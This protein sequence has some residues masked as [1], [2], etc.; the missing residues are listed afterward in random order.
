MH[1]PSVRMS[2]MQP[3]RTGS[4]PVKSFTLRGCASL[5]CMLL[6]ILA[7]FQAAW[8]GPGHDHADEAPVASGDGPARAADGS[9]FLPKPSQRQL[10]IRTRIAEAGEAPRSMAL[11]GQ[12]VMDPS[13][14]GKVQAAMAGRIEAGPAGLPALGARVSA[15]QVLAHIRPVA[16]AIERANQAAADAELRSALEIARQRVVRLDQ[17]E[18]SVPQKD[19]DAARA[20]LRGLTE[21]SRAVAGSLAGREALVAPVSGVIAS[22]NAV[23]GQIV[24][25]REL[26]FEIIDPARLRV[27]ALAFDP[28]M[29]QAITGAAA[30][31]GG[32]KVDLKPLGAARSLRDGALPVQFAVLKAADA[33]LALGMPV[34][35][36]VA[37]RERVQGVVLPAAAVVRN[38]AN[39]DIV[40]VHEAAERFVP[41][42][43]RAQAV[44]GATVVITDGLKPG[45]RVVVQGAALV[46]QVR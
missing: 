40:W 33:P 10:M 21:R 22:A 19:I 9:V 24:D 7:P 23:V 5:A 35:V 15:G 45:Q 32:R 29:A 20:E 36:F 18:G 43:V 11:M 28:A 2:N 4:G 3:T 13:A 6:L 17:L 34:K 8:A 42:P 38:P 44:D 31:V 37:T 26:V 12:V 1:Q 27:E 39:L 25:A 41:T 46:N 30:V 14:G 16:G